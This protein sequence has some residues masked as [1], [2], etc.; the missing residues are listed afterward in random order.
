MIERIFGEKEKKKKREKKEKGGKKKRNRDGDDG[1][2]TG[3]DF[4]YRLM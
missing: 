2:L 1:R 4:Q 3:W